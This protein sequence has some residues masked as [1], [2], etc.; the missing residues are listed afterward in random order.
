MLVDRHEVVRRG[1]RALIQ[2]LPGLSVCAEAA[3]AEDALVLASEMQP[4]I[5]VVDILMPQISGIDLT[6]QLKRLMPEVEILVLTMHGSERV[7]GQ[8]LRAGVR[9]YLLKS[10]DGN[11]IVEAILALSRHRPYFS[12]TVSEALLKQYL[13]CG[14]EFTEPLLTSRERQVVKLIAEGK[15]NKVMA[16]LLRRSIKTIEIHRAS[17]MRKIGAKSKAEIALYALRNELV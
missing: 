14:G 1:V 3:T 13:T 2:H 17:A 5:V 6:V 16:H 10:A 15:S 9:G 7:V 12:S 11:E 8:A 4:D